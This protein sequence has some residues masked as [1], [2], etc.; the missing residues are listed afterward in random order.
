[1]PHQRNSNVVEPGSLDHGMSESLRVK[2][3]GLCRVLE[4]SWTSD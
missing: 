1:M 3:H 2:Q 4:L